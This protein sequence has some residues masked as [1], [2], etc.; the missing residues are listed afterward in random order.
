MLDYY[1]HHHNVTKSKESLI[2][3]KETKDEKDNTNN[4]NNS[5]NSSNSSSS[6]N[7]NNIN[8]SAAKP[9][10]CEI[11]NDNCNDIHVKDIHN[12]LAK[13]KERDIMLSTFLYPWNAIEYRMKNRVDSIVMYFVLYSMPGLSRDLGKIVV[14]YHKSTNYLLQLISKEQEQV[15]NKNKSENSNVSIFEKKLL[16]GL[17]LNES[18]Q[19]WEH[20]LWL[21]KTVAYFEFR[22]DVK[23][24]ETELKPWIYSNLFKEYSVSKIRPENSG[25]KQKKQKKKKNKS[26]D[27]NEN[28]LKQEKKDLKILVGCWRWPSLK[29]GNQLH[30]N[31]EYAKHGLTKDKRMGY[32]MKC[33]KYLQLC[34]SNIND[35]KIDLFVFE[36]LD[37]FAKEF[38]KDQNVEWKHDRIYSYV[39]DWIIKDSLSQTNDT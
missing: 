37:L 1:T 33:L 30:K 18:K 35:S 36:W 4:S 19:D 21:V 11:K 7:S 20:V 24:V 28:E 39:V 22:I 26:N 2:D 5:S 9:E 14:M 8:N 6:N 15:K 16:C 27:N 31:K 13:E 12:Y 17:F 38:E 10:I 25:K 29:D 32:L 34:D 23:F 3:D